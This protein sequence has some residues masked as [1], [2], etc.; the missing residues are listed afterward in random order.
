MEEVPRDARY[1]IQL[2][3]NGLGERS[4]SF[5]GNENFSDII[6]IVKDTCERLS[7]VG[8]IE[9]LK[10]SQ[11]IRLLE[12]IPVTNIYS[13][14]YLKEIV[15]SGRIY[16]RPIQQSIKLENQEP[17]LRLV[18]KAS[19]QNCSLFFPITQLRDHIAV[20][21]SDSSNDSEI[22]ESRSKRVNRNGRSYTTANQQTTTTQASRATSSTSNRSSAPR[23]ATR[24]SNISI[25]TDTD[26]DFIVGR[27]STATTTTTTNTNSSSMVLRSA[28]QPIAY[29]TGFGITEFRLHFGLQGEWHV[30]VSR[31]SILK[32]TLSKINEEEL[33]CALKK[34]NVQLSSEDAVDQGGV[35]IAFYTELLRSIKSNDIFLCGEN[36][37]QMKLNISFLNNY[38]YAA[39]AKLIVNM[40]L[41]L[42]HPLG[43]FDDKYW[44]LLCGKPV[45]FEEDD[46]VDMRIKSSINII[47]GDQ[48]WTSNEEVLSVLDEMNV[49][50]ISD[51]IIEPDS[52]VKQIVAFYIVQKNYSAIVQFRDALKDLDVFEFL[53]A[54]VEELLPKA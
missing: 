41:F 15:G 40:L 16:V 22:F 37:K 31:E 26:D 33:S 54:N 21:H 42:N 12:D 50:D 3:E 19:C 11:G 7:N 48:N 36:K 45:V 49:H 20:C 46:L 8:G 29:A 35:L 28:S 1:K 23:T 6:E 18:P 24:S 2:E 52:L 10:C 9:L 4:I 14:R 30:F 51:F 34:P 32:D 47:K 43:L 25:D 5:Y 53:K 39:F 13:P 27:N 38:G 44:K 17:D